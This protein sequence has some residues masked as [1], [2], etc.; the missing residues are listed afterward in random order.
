MPGEQDPGTCLVPQQPL[1]HALLPEAFQ[2]S[3]IRT[4]CNPYEFCVNGVG[5]ELI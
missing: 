3:G 4:V 1:H 2:Y 5:Y